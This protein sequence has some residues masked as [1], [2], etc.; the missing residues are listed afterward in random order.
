MRLL[1]SFRPVCARILRV[2]VAIASATAYASLCT[3]TTLPVGPI[4]FS[5]NSD[6]DNKFKEPPF[7]NGILR[8]PNGYLELS[9]T[10]TGMAV[11]D[12]SATGGA[13]GQGGTGGLDVNSDLSNFTISADVASSVAGGIG[14]GFLLRLNSS[15]AA[16][17]VAGA[18]FF[19][20]F[21]TGTGKV[22]F[23]VF[24]GAGFTGAGLRIFHQE[25]PV[26]STPF[27]NMFYNFRVSVS[28][29]TFSFDFN[30]G[31]ATAGFTDT[32]VIATS[33]QVGIVLDTAS[34]FAATRL[35]NL[36]VEDAPL[37]VPGTSDPWLAG[38]PAGST[39]SN[40][41]VAPQHSPVEVTGITLVPGTALTFGAEGLVRYGPG[42]PGYGPD[43]GEITS[44]AFYGAQNGIS[45][46]FAPTCSLVGVF[47]DSARPDLSPPPQALDFSSNPDFSTLSPRLKQVFFIGDGRTSASTL[48]QFVVPSGATRLFLGT[49]DGW[50]WFNNQG[51][52][53]VEVHVVAEPSA[54]C[55][56][57]VGAIGF[58]V[59]AWRRRRSL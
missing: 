58:V 54:L 51:S 6:Y 44:H 11:F 19:P 15:E 31:A 18:H 33:G 41:D 9:G 12:T 35:D 20:P 3:A 39:A 34:A 52:F 49:M 5:S 46:V 45:D 14:V 53:T 27:A 25:V 50:G 47:L 22:A 1:A 57:S 59:G 13:N 43:G 24:E 48:Q 56:L 30:H 26:S 23:D 37:A 40:G 42:S 32:T 29:G 7:Y 17:Y 21:T 38:M 16:G 28:G 10:P 36:T 4:T 55:L 8:S 2:F